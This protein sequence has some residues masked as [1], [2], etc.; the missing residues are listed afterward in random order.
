MPA[1]SPRGDKVAYTTTEGRIVFL[2]A[3]LGEEEA[4][5]IEGWSGKWDMCSFSP[6][7]SLLACTYLDP[8]E[9]DKL[10]LAKIDI[11]RKQSRLVMGQFGPEFSP[12]WSPTG[13]RIAYAYAHC[14]SECGRI[15][16]ELWGV[17]ADGKEARQLAL[18][19]ANCSSPRWSPDGSE[20]VFSA[21][22]AD[23][24]DIWEFD[25]ET[26]KLTRLTE[27]PGLDE[28]AVFG[29]AGRHVAFISNRSGRGVI[30]VKALETGQLTELKP[31]GERAIE[32][33]DLAWR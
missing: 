22:I 8:K 14:S 6:D 33:K 30:W 19:N 7:G 23:N 31:F 10:A 18:T 12:A 27:A 26:G 21:D 2:D 9:G 32:V 24:F 28:S 29:P 16:Q 1:L 17:D 25:L 15:I 3:S 20:I 13:S 11:E 5:G 4:L